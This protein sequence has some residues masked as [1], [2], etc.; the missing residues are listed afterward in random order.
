MK[1]LHILGDGPNKLADEVISVHAKE[2]EVK[3]VDLSKGAISYDTLVDDIFAY[4]KV[5]SW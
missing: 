2:H 4:D 3:V 5:F 1:T